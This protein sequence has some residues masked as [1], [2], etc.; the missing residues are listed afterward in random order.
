VDATPTT[1]SGQGG[2]LTR[3]CAAAC[4]LNHAAI[5]HAFGDCN[6]SLDAPTLTAE[7]RRV[8][9]EA[10][11]PW[12]RYATPL[13]LSAGEV[14]RLRGPVGSAMHSLAVDE[15]HRGLPEDERFSPRLEAVEQRLVRAQLDAE[16]ASTGLDVPARFACEDA[17][18]LRGVLHAAAV[19]LEDYADRRA[20][21]DPPYLL[22]TEYF[23]KDAAQ[24]R[25]WFHATLTR[26]QQRGGC[27]RDEPAIAATLELDARDR[28]HLQEQAHSRRQAREAAQRWGG[29]GSG[30]GRER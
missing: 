29:R 23:T 16:R 9:P 18:R 26:Q 14:S 22:G 6:A 27:V 28:Q 21:A 5:P 15:D 10:E 1:S 11:L 7:Q 3:Y 19:R 4:D 12:V 8:L 17:N 2:D 30:V 25:D 13:L 20:A 24:L